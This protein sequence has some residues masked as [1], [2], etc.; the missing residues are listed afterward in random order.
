MLE[1]IYTQLFKMLNSISA[2]FVGIPTVHHV[3]YKYANLGNKTI[4]VS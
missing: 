1:D 3:I 4:I 2:Q